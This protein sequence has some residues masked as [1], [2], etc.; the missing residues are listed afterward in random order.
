MRYV[1]N[2][3][4]NDRKSLFI[5]FLCSNQLWSKPTPAPEQ[6]TVC[7]RKPVS[8]LREL[9]LWKEE[10]EGRR[11]R[12]E[13]EWGVLQACFQMKTIWGGWLYKQAIQINHLRK[14]KGSEGGKEEGQKTLGA[15]KSP[16]RRRE[17]RFYD[18][19]KTRREG[20]DDKSRSTTPV[21][22]TFFR[23]TLPS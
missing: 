19:K 15:G 12:W 17:K 11:R 5:Y 10:G 3:S 13:L 14:S 1:F 23:V 20:A 16:R 2:H 8:L 4:C 9:A 22:T 7:I 6:H 21:L 18:P